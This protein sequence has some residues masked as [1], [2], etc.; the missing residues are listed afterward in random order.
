MEDCVTLMNVLHH[1]SRFTQKRR[2]DF[3]ICRDYQGQV[4]R[5]WRLN[6]ESEWST[7]WH[8]VHMMGILIFFATTHS[9]P[10]DPHPHPFALKLFPLDPLLPCNPGY[11]KTLTLTILILFHF[12]SHFLSPIIALRPLFPYNSY[13]AYSL[14]PLIPSQFFLPYYSKSSLTFAPYSL[15]IFPP[16]RP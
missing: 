9:I 15:T 8:H 7:G 3:A 5:L 11:L 4:S 14:S 1:K 13:G 16:L 6:R 2:S 10:H 12:S